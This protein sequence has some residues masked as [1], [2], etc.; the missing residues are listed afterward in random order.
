[1]CWVQ[2][3]LRLGDQQMDVIRHCHIPYNDRTMALTNLFENLPKQIAA[4][5]C[6][7]V[8]AGNGSNCKRVKTA[9]GAKGWASPRC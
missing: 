7:E 5:R 8:S 1:M 3:P 9:K 6:R 2:Y 4:A